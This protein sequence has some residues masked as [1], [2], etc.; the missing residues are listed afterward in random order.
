MAVPNN[1]AQ[2]LAAL[3]QK[4]TQ[5]GKPS[6]GE[7]WGTVLGANSTSAEFA[8]RHSAVV[9][10]VNEIQIFLESLPEDDELR[11]DHLRD[12]PTYYSAVVYHGDW[13]TRLNP[14]TL[15]ND[16][17]I[18]LLASLGRDIRHRGVY[19]V[20]TDADVAKLRE[21]LQAWEEMLDGADLPEGINGEIRA[22]LAAIRDLLSQADILSY[23]PAVKEVETL[24]GKAVRIAK[25]VEDGK[26]IAGCVTGLFEF[27]THLSV[28]DL[29]STMNA[30][31]GAF[32]VMGEALQ[33]AHQQRRP[34]K[35]I[36]SAGRPALEAP[37]GEPFVDA[38]VV[39]D[40]GDDDAP[41]SR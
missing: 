1:P 38:E 16:Q 32:S 18:R 7:A 30:L 26:K 12:M 14:G 29:P 37:P 21:S 28:G 36:E 17:Q 15:I 23:G 6:F 13:N 8:R 31:V 19:P 39:D 22:Q 5:S 27:L 11:V 3:L 24:F 35:A 34:Q 20:V 25:Y 41:G 40:D 33:T 2:A 4:V 10:L 9:G